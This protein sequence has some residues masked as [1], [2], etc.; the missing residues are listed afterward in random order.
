MY[1]L[2]CVFIVYY[3][4]GDVCFL[5]ALFFILASVVRLNEMSDLQP[6]YIVMNFCKPE[7]TRKHGRLGVFS[8]VV[9]TGQLLREGRDSS[10]AWMHHCLY[11][12][13]RFLSLPRVS[14]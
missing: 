2:R 6:I 1:L 13:S 5:S 10:L 12:N 9:L 8:Q 3:P 7:L 11:T 4:Q 14:L